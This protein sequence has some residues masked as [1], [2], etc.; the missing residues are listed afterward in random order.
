MSKACA[1]CKYEWDGGQN[2]LAE[3][4]LYEN[5]KWSYQNERVTKRRIVTIKVIKIAKNSPCCKVCMSCSPS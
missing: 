2:A 3:R 4:C 5:Y 1:K